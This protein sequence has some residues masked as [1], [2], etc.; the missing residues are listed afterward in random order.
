MPGFREHHPTTAGRDRDGESPTWDCSGLRIS[1]HLAEGFDRGSAREAKP[2]LEE[3]AEMLN[4]VLN[5]MSVLLLGRPE[6]I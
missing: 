4:S 5:K 3:L 1:T 6:S 2:A